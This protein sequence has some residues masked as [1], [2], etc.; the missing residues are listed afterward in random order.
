MPK[1]IHYKTQLTIYKRKKV[2]LELKIVQTKLILLEL[3]K[4][5][6]LLFKKKLESIEILNYEISLF[7]YLSVF[8]DML[9]IEKT[10]N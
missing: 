3:L 5:I 9:I 2:K 6:L 10:K 4:K 1:Q 7:I 8:I